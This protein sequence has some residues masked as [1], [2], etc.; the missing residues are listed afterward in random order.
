MQTD[1]NFARTLYDLCTHRQYLQKR[2][3]SQHMPKSNRIL[4]WWSTKLSTRMIREL[5][6]NKSLDDYDHIRC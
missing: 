1:A 3:Y 2:K 6:K 5:F 4:N